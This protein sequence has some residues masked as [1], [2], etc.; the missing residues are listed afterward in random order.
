MK[1]Q[2]HADNSV[3]RGIKCISAS[4]KAIP[5]DNVRVP[6]VQLESNVMRRSVQA[7]GRCFR[8]N[9]RASLGSRAACLLCV[10][11]FE[12]KLHGLLWKEGEA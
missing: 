1:S 8:C 4:F 11:R 9:T 5:Q 12:W 3:G 6:E 2:F 7:L 10:P